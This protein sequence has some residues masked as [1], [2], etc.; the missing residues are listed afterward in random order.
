M[1]S[2]RTLTKYQVE[3]IEQLVN[4]GKEVKLP[5]NR[6]HISDKQVFYHQQLYQAYENYNLPP[7]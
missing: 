1:V 2:W 5:K 7:K 4:G 3:I 6:R